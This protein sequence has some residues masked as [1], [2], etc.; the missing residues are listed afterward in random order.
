M[1]T[2]RIDLVLVGLVATA[3]ASLGATAAYQVGF[4]VGRPLVKRFGCYVGLGE[5]EVRWTEAW[6]AKYGDAG[7]LIGH[8]LPGVRSFTS[9]LAGIARMGVRRYVSFTALGSGIWN[10]ALALAGFYLLTGWFAFAQGAEGIDLVLLLA[11]ITVALGYIHWRK[12]VSGVRETA[13]PSPPPK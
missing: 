8:A 7:N 1:A 3:G 12:R 6:F 13:S 9:F 10:V 2:G 11:A 5:P 4:Y